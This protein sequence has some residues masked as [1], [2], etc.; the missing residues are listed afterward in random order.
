[1]GPFVEPDPP[2]PVQ[3]RAT[4]NFGR[5]SVMCSANAE[6]LC[7]GPF[8]IIHPL[9]LELLLMHTNNTAQATS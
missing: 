6:T 2:T 1:M 7:Q 5:I 8:F 3:S 9:L 4:K